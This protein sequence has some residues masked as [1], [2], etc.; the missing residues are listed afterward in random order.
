[1]VFPMK[2]QGAVQWRTHA[3][4]YDGKDFIS[5]KK[6]CLIMLRLYIRVQ[7]IH[8][9]FPFVGNHSTTLGNS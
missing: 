2:K 9:V 7:N 4:V 8:D 1:M 3:P 6:A 5:W